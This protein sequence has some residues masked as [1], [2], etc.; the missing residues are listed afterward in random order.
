[1]LV[2]TALG[3]ASGPPGATPVKVYVGAG[4]LTA[5]IEAALK[6]ELSQVVVTSTASEAHLRVETVLEGSQLQLTI[7]QSPDV[8]VGHQ[9]LGLNEDPSPTVRVVT[10]LVADALEA[11]QHR[12]L[13]QGP[14]SIGEASLA[15]SEEQTPPGPS[16]LE[17]PNP[18]APRRF[19]LAAA[20]NAHLWQRPAT[21]SVGIGLTALWPIGDVVE[22]GGHV[23]F[24]GWPC[25]GIESSRIEGRALE[26]QALVHGDWVV[27]KGLPW[28]ISVVTRAG[29][30]LENFEGRARFTPV[31]G[32][33]IES[34]AQSAVALGLA[35]QLGVR[36]GLQLTETVALVAVAG[37]EARTPRLIVRPPPVAGDDA[38]VDGGPLSPWVELGPRL[39]FF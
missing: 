14:P 9:T 20:V 34:S 10:L 33:P 12:R 8:V 38:A 24:R 26:V 7:R 22:L 37:L 25:C 4:P 31:A 36:L 1:M 16:P 30:R 11:L 19:A 13:L 35:G 18:G 23:A 29:L 21:P 32:G 6:L 5:P 28:T 3:L 27:F 39:D 15:T 17:S 2:F